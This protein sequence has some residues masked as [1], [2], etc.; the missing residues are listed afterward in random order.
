[1]ATEVKMQSLS[2]SNL[3]NISYRSIR[4]FELR[5]LLSL[6]FIV[7]IAIIDWAKILCF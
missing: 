3:I 6:K 5:K 1:M 7:N 4:L 2:K